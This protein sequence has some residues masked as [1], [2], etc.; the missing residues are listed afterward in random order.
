MSSTCGVASVGDAIDAIQRLTILL[1]RA[2]GVIQKI[3]EL[4]VLGGGC[5][6]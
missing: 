3:V 2:G 6:I 5:K 4:S 1:E